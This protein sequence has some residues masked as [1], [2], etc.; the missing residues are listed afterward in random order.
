MGVFSG[1]T[2]LG[3]AMGPLLLSATGYVGWLPFLAAA[4]ILSVGILPLL[5]I[6]RGIPN[7]AAES[8]AEG[9]VSSWSFAKIAPA[10]LLAFG[11]VAIYDNVTVAFLPLYGAD[12]GMTQAEAAKLLSVAMV[13][14][15]LFQLPIG[16]LADRFSTTAVMIGCG[17][18][19]ALGCQFFPSVGS[20]LGLW[21]LCFVIGGVAFGLQTAVMTEMSSRFVGGYLAAGNVAIGLMAGGASM[22]AM[23]V[24]GTAMDLIGPNGYPV[25][26]GAVFGGIALIYAA[27]ALRSSR[28]SDAL[29]EGAARA[30]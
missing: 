25:I 28:R 22:V 15:V 4:L 9:Q 20:D 30:A 19:V 27:K 3:Y 17:G 26:I 14:A 1:V 6:G 12:L 8:H 16:Y 24:T 18:L 10:L 11:A 29:A 7:V 5:L 2:V 21:V 23:P 13:G